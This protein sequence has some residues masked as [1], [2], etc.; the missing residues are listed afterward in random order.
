MRGEAATRRV[1]K[2]WNPLRYCLGVST[3]FL[4]LEK[5]NVCLIFVAVQV[6]F[7][8][9]QKYVRSKRTFGLSVEEIVDCAR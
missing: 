2:P 8:I 1:E 6:T 3:I 5:I 4:G 7:A 9:P